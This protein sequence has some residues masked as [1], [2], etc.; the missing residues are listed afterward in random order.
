MKP[1]VTQK[2]ANYIVNKSAIKIPL[3]VILRK[4]HIVYTK[5]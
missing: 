4:T 1:H 2:Q 5:T 3:L